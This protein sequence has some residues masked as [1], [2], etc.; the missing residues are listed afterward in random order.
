MSLRHT[1]SWQHIEGLTKSIMTLAKKQDWP[2]VNELAIKRHQAVLKHFDD[3]P[4]GPETAEFYNDH[5]SRFLTQ[6]AHITAL[7]TDA[8]KKVMQQGLALQQS[9]KAVSAYHK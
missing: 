8:R 5:L 7:A 2:E 3:F 1:T 9:Q 6:E 4:V